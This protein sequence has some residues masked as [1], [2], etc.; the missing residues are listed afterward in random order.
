[1]V[2]E[3]NNQF[4]IFTKATSNYFIDDDVKQPAILKNAVAKENNS[5]FHLFTHGKPGELLING[6]WLKKEEIASFL[7]QQFTLSS[8][9]VYIR[10]SEINIYGCNFAQG[11]KGLEAVAYLEKATGLKVSASSN[12]T[13]AD[14]DWTLEVGTPLK[15]NH[16]EGYNFNLQLD[17]I[18]YFGPHVGS[19]STQNT[20]FNLVNEEVTLS[21]PSASP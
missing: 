15:V 16:V 12:I 18:H 6:K 3:P 11:E 7:M 17:T 14:G 8:G 19:F 2:F 20:N 1:M 10:N 4:T 13:G 21:T 9:E 5:V